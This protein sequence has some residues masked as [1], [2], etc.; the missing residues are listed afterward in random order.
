MISAASQRL[1][2]G[3]FVTEDAGEHALKGFAEPV[4]VFRVR[5][6]S[7][8]R[9]RLDASDGRSLTPLVGRDQEL[10]LLLDRWKSVVDGQGQVVLVTGDPGIGKSRLVQAVSARI[11]DEPHTRLEFRCSPTI[12]TARCTR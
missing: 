5:A 8:V 4:H 10:G 2:Q 7:G 1:V 11:A 6:E 9:N 3:F 12:S